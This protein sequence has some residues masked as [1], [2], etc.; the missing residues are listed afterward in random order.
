M[1]DSCHAV[2]LNMW[3]GLT[4]H[5]C[6]QHTS[7]VSL[8][9]S[10]T[11]SYPSKT[12]CNF[13]TTVVL[14]ECLLAAVNTSCRFIQLSNRHTDVGHT[15]RWTRAHWPLWPLQRQAPMVA[16]RPGGYLFT[17]V[18]WGWG[19]G[20]RVEEGETDVSEEKREVRNWG[21]GKVESG[22]QLMHRRRERWESQ[23]DSMGRG[24][25]QRGERESGRKH[26]SLFADDFESPPLYFFYSPP[27]LFFFSILL[28]IG[29]SHCLSDCLSVCL[30]S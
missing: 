1:M 7:G 19:V 12:W 11:H 28:Y 24:D 8:L 17:M 10:L 14:L 27:T 15:N 9:H 29:H 2:R 6:C 21:R 16:G 3:G 26:E 30:S 18:A 25:T 22:C 5:I 13:L 23:T 20:E 4:F